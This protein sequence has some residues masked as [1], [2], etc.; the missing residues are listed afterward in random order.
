MLLQKE[1][2]L[3]KGIFREYMKIVYIFGSVEQKEF[4][5]I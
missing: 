1:M 3:K 2:K 5:K 4:V